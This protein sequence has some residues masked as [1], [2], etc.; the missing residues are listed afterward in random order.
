MVANCPR[1]LWVEFQLK[2]ILSQT[3][4][5][6][7]ER[8]LESLPEDIEQ[9]YERIID[10]IDK[11]PKPQR[12]LAKRVFMWIAYA[13]RPMILEELV[14]AVAMKNDTRSTTE[15]ESMAPTAEILVSVRANLAVLNVD[16]FESTA[17][18]VHFSV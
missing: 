3:S 9:T 13:K 15:L 11:K 14:Y 10:I 7:I 8:A 5:Y 12:N 16:V 18:F 17:R 1:F 4:N 2:H 6:G